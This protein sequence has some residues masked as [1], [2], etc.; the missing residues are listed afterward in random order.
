MPLV[1]LARQCANGTFSDFRD[2]I[3]GDPE[4]CAKEFMAYCRSHFAEE[5]KKALAELPEEEKQELVA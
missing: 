5:I 4:A 3:V 2:T 1:D